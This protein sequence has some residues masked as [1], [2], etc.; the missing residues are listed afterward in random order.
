MAFQHMIAVTDEGEEIEIEALEGV[1][2]NGQVILDE[3]FNNNGT[4]LP[5]D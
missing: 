2:F 4:F 1:T 3:D 5:F